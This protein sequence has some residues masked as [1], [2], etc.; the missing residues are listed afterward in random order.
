MA[1]ESVTVT[2]PRPTVL[3]VQ[4]GGTVDKAYPNRTGGYAF[5]FADPPAAVRV[6]ERAV[7]GF[8]WELATVCK[9]D[10]LDMSGDD[11]AALRD[12]IVATPHT[13]IVVTHGSDTLAESARF[14][15]T[16]PGKTIVFTG[17]YSPERF[18]D[19]DADF[20]L[21]GATAALWMVTEGTFVCVNGIVMRPEGCGKEEGSGLFVGTPVCGTTA[22]S[23][24]AAQ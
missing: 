15:G 24:A 18:R 22:P 9:K 6:L 23:S 14:V 16:V 12:L 21:G 3:Y 2:G 4:C 11:R 10:S 1:D 19:S 17:S 8:R 13:K 5:E 7:P 20:N